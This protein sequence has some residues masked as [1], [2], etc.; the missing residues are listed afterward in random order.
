MMERG[1]RFRRFFQLER[2][3]PDVEGDVDAE[4]AFH[5]EMAVGELTG[6]GMSE[7]DARREAERRFGDVSRTRRELASLDR[8]R[9]G[10][11]RRAR[12]GSAIMQDLR[13]AARGLRRK[14][15]FTIAVMLTLGLGIGANA[16][17]FGIVDR[18]LF[19][20][21]AHLPE[22]GAVNRVYFVRNFDGIDRATSNTSYRR[23]HDIRGTTSSFSD[24][25]GFWRTELA[26]GLGEAAREMDVATV[27]PE[28]WRIFDAPP[29]RGR[30][31]RDDEDRLPAGAP[32][33]VLGYEYW[34]SELGG[35][36]DILGQQLHIGQRDYTVIG[37]APKGF[38]A[39]WMTPTTAFIP[40][41]AGGAELSA[42]GPDLPTEYGF[43][44]M[45]L[46]VRRKPGVTADAATQDLTRA[47][48]ASYAAQRAISPRTTPAEQARPRALATSILRERGPNQT[49]VAKVAKWLIG[50]SLVVLLIA[51]ANV[52][53][54]L[55]ARA[56][57]RRRE[58]AV[59]LALG[60][61]RGRLLG[62]LA[63]ESVL[64][65]ALGGVAGL[66]LAQW[67][68]ELI[69]LTLMPQVPSTN[70][71]LDGRV[72]GFTALAA[73]TAGLLAG[74]APVL[75]ARRADVAAALKAG[76]REGTYQ[77]SRM[78]MGLLVLQCA[79][80]VVLLVGA[81]LFVRSFRNV[82]DLRLGYDPDRVL[83]VSVQSRGVE[84]SDEAMD[85]L[86]ER[87]L[88][89]A[90]AVPGVEAATRTLTVPFFQSVDYEIYVPG[91]D[92]VQRLGIFTLQAGS[93]G[94][95]NTM[96]TRILRGRPITDED[97]RGAPLVMV[98][99]ESMAQAL[100]P[101]KDAI[102]ECV[103]VGAD[104][105]PCTTV[106]GVA[107]DIKRE[108]LTEDTGL[109]YYLSMAQFPPGAG[110]LFVRTRGPATEQSSAV[111]T[112]LQRLMPGA[113]Y[114]NVT[115]MEE[116]V[117]PNMRSW[118][119]GATMFTVFGMLA[120]VVAAVG[121]YSVIAYNVSQRTHELGVR[122]ALG[123]RTTDIVRIVLTDA[124]KL[125]LA[126]VVLGTIAVLYA[127]KWLEPMLYGTSARDPLVIAAIGAGLLAIA[128]VA[129]FVPALRA[130]RVDPAVALRAD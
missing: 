22:P 100:W 4:L 128:A 30:Y 126:A 114:V 96:G 112:A 118:E 92:S 46:L 12:W 40:L 91:I 87:I 74:L 57:G 23:Y 79:L 117:A 122:V 88:A 124:M 27:T 77:K 121:L 81:A 130:S 7:A 127:G 73:L 55:L 38:L 25:A 1:S 52:G 125:A 69:R 21:P 37:V 67:G 129:S 61:S 26:I 34:Q 111:R 58:I 95:F 120:L 108:S 78:R 68:G 47:Y 106:V 50:V 107:E 109:L 99:S 28:F 6:R 24:I 72:L 41:T 71:M 80:S 123:A 3:A 56:L 75:Q 119:L 62:Q 116:F 33:T 15:G 48:L 85:V 113:S 90:Q 70:T 105:M 32:V 17:M 115:P 9:A 42:G 83:Y 102:G 94:Y 39:L 54:L 76:A 60:V 53:N 16:T 101:G 8:A 45:E 49:T 66:M 93:P 65:A 11:E 103:K 19:R 59:R 63:L 43:N 14:P 82:N 10:N 51:C 18:L 98:A 89:A 5:F 84:L 110:G 64:L 20:P 35:R 2:H 29:A 36:S 44:W 86:K 104:T 31:F 13:Y 97:R